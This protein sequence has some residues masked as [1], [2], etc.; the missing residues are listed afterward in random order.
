[1]DELVIA[2]QQTS[3]QAERCSLYEQAQQ[4]IA[5]D[6]ATVNGSV[7]QFPAVM[8]DAVEGYQYN[9]AHDLTVNVNDI[10]LDE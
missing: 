2:A 1:M 9:G 10:W 7:Q 8:R 3:D 5:S 4:I 6:Y